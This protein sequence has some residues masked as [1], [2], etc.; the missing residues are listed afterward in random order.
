MPSIHPSAVVNSSARL[1]DNVVVG[2]FSVVGPDVEL[3]EDVHVSS[4]VVIDGVTR[5]GS[6]TR[7]FPF[8]SVGL[9]PQDLKYQG[10]LSRLEIGSNCII[11][12]HVTINTGT[13]GGGMLTTVGDRVMLAI[14][15]HV[16]H[17]C[18]IGNGVLVM[19]H[20]LL[21]GHV[22]IGDFAVIG[23]GSAV[24]QFA[25]IGCHVM[26]GGLSGVEGDVIPYGTV[27]GNRARLEGLNLVGLKRR[28]FGRSDI[29]ALRNAFKILFQPDDPVSVLS[30]RI[31]DVRSRWPDSEPVQDVVRFIDADSPRSLCRP[32]G[33]D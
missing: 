25:R 28:G 21:G 12:E 20:V 13:N 19:N 29:H 14:G 6:G 24:H 22:E 5:I 1:A 32:A 30:D 15:C 11:R 10:E 16:A 8:A 23:G 26:V 2:P 9:A 33:Y 31:V 4:H 27:I 3:G 18:R 7:I 17:D